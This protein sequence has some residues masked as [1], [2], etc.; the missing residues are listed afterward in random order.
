MSHIILDLG[1]M[2]AE[3]AVKRSARARRLALRIDPASGGAVI[4]LPAR[5][6]LSDAERFARENIV[7]LAER[8]ARLPQAVRFLPNAEVPLLGEPHVIHHH[9]GAR[10][11]VWVE[12]GGIHVSGQAE[13]VERR[14]TDFLKA[15]A[16]RIILPKAFEMA[17]AISRTPCRVTVKDT[18]SRWGSCSSRGDLAFSWRLVLAPGWILD[19]VVAHEVAHLAELNHSAAFWTVVAGLNGDAERARKWLKLHGAGLH[20]Y[21]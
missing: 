3:I 15:E 7:W 11:G 21:G 10:R 12:E 18:R 19:Y 4:T 14:V 13:H 5:T 1:G 20:R 6:P 16:R 17:Q 2:T 9:A 8:L